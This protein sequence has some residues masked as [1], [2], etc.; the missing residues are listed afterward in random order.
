MDPRSLPSD[1]LICLPFLDR[2]TSGLLQVADDELQRRGYSIRGVRLLRRIAR[3]G[4]W[5]QRVAWEADSLDAFDVLLGYGLLFVLSSPFV[6][7]VCG[8]TIGRHSFGMIPLG[9]GLGLIA[10][11]F[12]GFRFRLT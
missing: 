3:P 12:A 9:I 8:L 7:M 4:L 10:V 1:E 2:D 5:F 11:A 6:A